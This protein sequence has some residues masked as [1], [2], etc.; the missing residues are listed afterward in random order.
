MTVVDWHPEELIDQRRA[1]VLRDADARRLDE[2][3]ATCAACRFELLCSD[4]F[5]DEGADE[6]APQIAARLALAALRPAAPPPRAGTTPLVGRALLVALTVV[7]V[8]GVAA[9]AYLAGKHQAEPRRSVWSQPTVAFP[10][11][12]VT[13]SRPTASAA[14]PPPEPPGGAAP[15]S[16]AAS[17]SAASLFARANEARRQGS[18]PRALALY[19]ELQR[20]HPGSPEAR[21]SQAIVGRVLLEEDPKAALDAY[22]AYLEEGGDLAEEALVGRAQAQQ[23][24]GDV[25]GERAAWQAL[26][27]RFPGSLHAAR[28][29]ARLAELGTR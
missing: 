2:H 19:R 8:A 3:L 16:S 15:S 11:T 12:L 10:A 7:V 14:P 25:A 27:A 18:R 21:L 4:D 5:E 13:A 26:L 6:E 17:E 9:A 23:R 29:R 20:R 1:G 28:A 24:L 22:D